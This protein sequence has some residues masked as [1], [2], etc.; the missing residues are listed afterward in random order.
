MMNLIAFYYWYILLA[1]QEHTVC[2]VSMYIIVLKLNVFA[3]IQFWRY[4]P[5]GLFDMFKSILHKSLNLV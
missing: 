5:R 4:K 2:A 1:S 3:S